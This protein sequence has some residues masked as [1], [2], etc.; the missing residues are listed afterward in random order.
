VDSMGMA[1][2]APPNKTLGDC[3]LS[4]EIY[5]LERLQDDYTR[6]VTMI[7]SNLTRDVNSTIKIAITAAPGPDPY[8][9]RIP[10]ISAADW[11]A[12]AQNN[13]RLELVLV[14]DEE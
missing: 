11:N 13:N 8:P 3:M 10:L 2:L 12:L 9:E 7:L 1:Q 5:T 14:A 6:E 4:S